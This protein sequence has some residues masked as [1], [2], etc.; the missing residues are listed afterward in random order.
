MDHMFNNVLNKDNVI[1]D[2][3]VFGEWYLRSKVKAA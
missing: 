1:R 2:K 3:F